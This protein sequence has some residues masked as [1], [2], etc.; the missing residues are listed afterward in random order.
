MDSVSSGSGLTLTL[1]LTPA[2]PGVREEEATRLSFPLKIVV[3]RRAIRD[4]IR[5]EAIAPDG[6]RMTAPL[7]R[8][9]TRLR[10][11]AAGEADALADRQLLGRYL[12][13]KDGDA[14]AVL[15][16]RHG[17]LVLGVCRRVL[18]HTQDAEDA[19][20]AAFLVLAR[21]AA[22]IA[23]RGA[24]RCWLHGVAFRVSSSL[25]RQRQR[26]KT[27][28]LAEPAVVPADDVTWRELRQILDEELLRLPEQFRL[29][30]L[31]CY[32]EGKTRDEA[33]EELGWTLTTF[34]GRLE[35]A[36]DRLRAR[37]ER[38][39]IGLPAA[40]LALAV[41]GP[42]AAVPTGLVETIGR[43]VG[44]Q[45]SPAAAALAEGA[46]RTMF[47][48][49]ITTSLGA[50]LLAG[51]LGAGSLLWRGHPA[52]EAA[53]TALAAEEQ[54]QP[55]PTKS[56]PADAP[57]TDDELAA[58]V[59]KA[60]EDAVAWLKK[61]QK[62]D[63][64]W[65]EGTFA[66]G[67]PGG[68]T[69]LA[70]YAL[71]EG[72]ADASDPAV[73]RALKVLRGLQPKATYVVA[74]QTAALCKANNLKDAP[75]VQRNVDW[76][77]EAA[78]RNPNNTLLGWSY[79]KTEPG[80]GRADFSN[81][82]FAVMG[83]QAAERV[84]IK[85]KGG[86]LWKEI[87]TLYRAV[88]T[89]GGGWGYTPN[90]PPTH[91]MTC[92]GLGA[93]LTADPAAAE[94]ADKAR[95]KAMAWL[96]EHFTPE[97]G[98][99]GFYNLHAAARAGALAGER[100]FGKHDW[101][102]EG[103]LWML[104]QRRDDG[105]FVGKS[106]LDGT[107]T[108]ST[109]FALL[110]FAAAPEPKEPPKDIKAEPVG[111]EPRN[112]WTS[113]SPDGEDERGL[114][115]VGAYGK[116]KYSDA[117]LFAFAHSGKVPTG[118]VEL[119]GRLPG[120]FFADDRFETVSYTRDGDTITARLRFR[121]GRAAGASDHFAYVRGRLPSLPKDGRTY[122]VSVVVASEENALA[123]EVL[124]CTVVSGKAPK[125]DATPPKVEDLAA[126]ADRILVVTASKIPMP[127]PQGNVGTQFEVERVLKGPPLKVLRLM[128]PKEEGGTLLAEKGKRW[129]IF[130][131]CDEEGPDAPRFTP[132]SPTWFLP[133][134]AEM[135]QK[136]S[137]SIPNPPDG[138][139][140]DT[141][142]RL[143]LHLRT[144]RVPAGGEVAVEVSLRNA[145]DGPLP[146]QAHRL[147]IYDYWPATTFRVIDPDGRGWVLA[148]PKG[149]MSESDTAKVIELAPGER[150][151]QVMRLNRWPATS[152]RPNSDEQ[153]ADLFTRP[154]KYIIICR[155]EQRQVK[156]PSL[157]LE[158]DG[159]VLNVTPGKAEE[160]VM[161]AYRDNLDSFFLQ[162]K[163][164]PGLGAAKGISLR[165]LDLHVAN[166]RYEPHATDADG[167]PV[168]ADV[169]LTRAQAAKVL[170]VLEKQG[171][172][173]PH[174]PRLPG[175]Y[176][177]PHLL[178]T[179]R[180]KDGAK[181]VE[182]T[183]RYFWDET[184]FRT[185]RAVKDAAGAEAAKPI[186]TLTAPI[187]DLLKERE[188]GALLG[189]WKID[190]EERDGDP[191][192]K[193]KIG[194]RTL[195]VRKWEKGVT[196]SFTSRFSGEVP[197]FVGTPDATVRPRA[198]DLF[199]A[200]DGPQPTSP[201]IYEIDK[202]RLRLRWGAAAFGGKLPQRP[203][204]FTTAKDKPG[205]LM[206]FERLKD[207]DEVPFIR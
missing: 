7:E 151:V 41:A 120:K 39:G 128:H 185:V 48:K 117:K 46:L 108:I 166:L 5:V 59:K 143:G 27:E 52:A 2:K 170:E 134:T 88:Q 73:Q 87:T 90:A 139:K 72:G 204:D 180:C 161:K 98:A 177:V 167:K 165:T 1:T 144:T 136:V 55:P 153:Q 109:S 31:L 10:E 149:D 206:E 201:C 18:G 142:I 28:P 24:L 65:E 47:V 69:A 77:A 126:T 146:V 3:P 172:F 171:F 20:Q 182:T 131:R 191:V 53:P 32:L 86:A 40:L 92:A 122:T 102:R 179:I 163:L 178:L 130:L 162:F 12:A 33:A 193:D 34:K 152:E 138:G 114:Y 95:A 118:A 60:R 17:P 45:A 83:L 148:K 25:R 30:L 145:T 183:V 23:K 150:Y 104:K 106:G 184:M 194:Y 101:F 57:P 100:T 43:A 141:P 119:I 205:V 68:V 6:T 158:S 155:Y 198:I 96:A 154:G 181:D 67:M 22:A 37:L 36:R 14:F 176:R 200:A 107:P 80:G 207:K 189:D 186:D 21:R 93:L 103:A 85:P 188:I 56:A 125:A 133:G 49:K 97:S 19:C 124:R 9:M 82:H 16:R 62:A 110:F 38:K 105:S 79:V 169:R 4:T 164:E 78:V 160:A 54:P 132:L 156:G 175:E 75:L 159:V 127:L 168:S 113:L 29:P 91:S 44:G 157:K 76:L 51:L 74:L 192:P 116:V 42:A 99:G 58:T 115:A 26:R 202:G 196:L 64:S 123:K 129:I 199:Q 8:T 190:R 61:V 135:V 173:G 140:I 111:L 187:A 89:Q 66:T 203:G 70:T 13:R 197:V 11:L 71:L 94:N 63:G 121:Q 137:A 50:L 195:T 84:N 35:R 15:V 174:D 112:F 81:S 147:N